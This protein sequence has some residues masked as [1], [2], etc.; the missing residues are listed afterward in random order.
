VLQLKNPEHDEE[1]VDAEGPADTAARLQ[2]ERRYVASH[3]CGGKTNVNTQAL[4]ELL[5]SLDVMAVKT[6]SVDSLRFM[7]V[8]QLTIQATEQNCNK[9]FVITMI[10]H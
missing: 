10:G 1:D 9:T 6:L 3:G 4:I 8:Q 5:L 7:E 2:A